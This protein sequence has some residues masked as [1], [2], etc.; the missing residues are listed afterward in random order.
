[1]EVIN[2]DFIINVASLMKKHTLPRPS[3]KY[4]KP[5]LHEDDVEIPIITVELE[6]WE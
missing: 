2:Q 4:C 6:V 5:I 3:R 1:M